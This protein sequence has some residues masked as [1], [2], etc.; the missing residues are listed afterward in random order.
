MTLIFEVI[1][2]TG[3]KIMLTKER[4]AHITSPQFLHAYMA[5]YLEDVRGALVNPDTIVS[6]NS[7]RTK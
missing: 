1:D 3:R 4:W 7:M 6:I 2:K 5:N